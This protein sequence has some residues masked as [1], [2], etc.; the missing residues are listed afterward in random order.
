[1]SPPSILLT[2]ARSLVPKLDELSCIAASFRPSIIIVSESW[3][4]DEISDQQLFLNNY[5]YPLRRDRIG[6]RGGGVCVYVSSDVQSSSLNVS[7]VS[8]THLTLPTILLV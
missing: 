3:L 4:N 5:G 7:T 6:K 1:M 8:Y 2:N